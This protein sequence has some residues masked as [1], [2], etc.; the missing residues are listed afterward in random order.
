MRAPWFCESTLTAVI[1]AVIFLRLLSRG[2]PGRHSR[3]KV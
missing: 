2:I 3:G 1:A